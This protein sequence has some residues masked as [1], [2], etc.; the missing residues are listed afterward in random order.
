MQTVGVL[1]G[2]EGHPRHMGYSDEC[3]Y[4]FEHNYNNL[5]NIECSNEGHIL[6]IEMCDRN[7]RLLHLLAGSQLLFQLFLALGLF[8]LL[9]LPFVRVF[10]FLEELFVRLHVNKLLNL[11]TIGAA[12]W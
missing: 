1:D 8:L 4:S 7:R 11:S 6:F 10:N 2:A 9:P 3:C 12:L 5:R